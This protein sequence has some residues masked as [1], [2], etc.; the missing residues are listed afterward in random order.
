MPLAVLPMGFLTWGC[1]LAFV[2]CLSPG[3]YISMQGQYFLWNEVKKNKELGFFE[4]I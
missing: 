4:R 1:A 3:V 2:Q